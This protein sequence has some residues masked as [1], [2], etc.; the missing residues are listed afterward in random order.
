MCP[1]FSGH[2]CSQH[3]YVSTIMFAGGVTICDGMTCRVG[4]IVDVEPHPN[5]DALYVEQ[6]NLGEE[7]PRQVG[8]IA[9]TPHT[10]SPFCCTQLLLKGIQMQVVSGLRNFVPIEQMK[11]RRV[12]VCTNLKP[13]KMREVMSYGMASVACAS[14][15]GV[16]QVLQSP[17]LAHASRARAEELPLNL[18]MMI[19]FLCVTSG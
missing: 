16:L 5:A 1:A 4:Q 2:H 6:I 7:K 11:G 9:C 13:A 18:P 19:T 14:D 10:A 15:Y 12:V 17:L 8:L 3:S